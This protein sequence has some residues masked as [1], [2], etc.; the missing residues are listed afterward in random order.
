[1]DGN[2]NRETAGETSLAVTDGAAEEFRPVVAEWCLDGDND[3]R[4]S[5]TASCGGCGG[6]CSCA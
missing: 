2:A 3:T 4:F 5:A 6:G 1:M